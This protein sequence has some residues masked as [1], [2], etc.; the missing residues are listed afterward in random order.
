LASVKRQGFYVSTS[1]VLRG[2]AI[3]ERVS[4]SGEG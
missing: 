4:H 3:Q 2:L 1:P